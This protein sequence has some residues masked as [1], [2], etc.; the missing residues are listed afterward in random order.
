MLTQVVSGGGNSQALRNNN[1]DNQSQTGGAG[2]A[3]NSPMGR[4]LFLKRAG[5]AGVGVAML[6]NGL[7]LKVQ[8]SYSGVDQKCCG[9]PM[10]HMRTS[11]CKLI[12]TH[13][14]T[15]H[16]SSPNSVNDAWSGIVLT[17][18]LL[19]TRPIESNFSDEP[20]CAT[21]LSHPTARVIIGYGYSL[22]TI[23]GVSTTGQTIYKTTIVIQEGCEMIETI[24]YAANPDHPNST[25]CYWG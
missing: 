4:R 17:G 7:M 18:H 10:P 15:W 1:F 24:G 12:Q 2:A 16:T 14:S 22:N 20:S 13:T 23:M 5:V 9:V 11:T 21:E 8:A 19:W 25:S 3:W 6:N